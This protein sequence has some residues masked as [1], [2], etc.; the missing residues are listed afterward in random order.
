MNL[1]WRCWGSYNDLTFKSIN[2]GS[3]DLDSSEEKEKLETLATENK[4]LLEKIQDNLKDKVDSVRLSSRLKSHPVCI[5]SG[6]GISFEME[7]GCQPI[8][9][10]EPA[11][12]SR[13]Y[14]GDQS[15]SSN[16]E[17]FTEYRGWTNV[18]WL[19]TT[20]L[21]SSVTH[22]GITDWKSEWVLIENCEPDG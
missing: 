13:A 17:C 19:F 11:R 10:W 7:K 16:L 8:T 2:Q 3:L 21:W 4:S 20:A 15:W 6:E 22:W 18:E 14:S 5:V 1:P 12:Q 9:G